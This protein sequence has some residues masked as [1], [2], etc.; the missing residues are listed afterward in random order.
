MARKE[1]FALDMGDGR[2]VRSLE[3]L[4]E[5]F[6]IDRVIGYFQD[7]S[8]LTWLDD[9]YYEEEA[10]AIDGLGMTDPQF[11]EKLCAALGVEYTGGGLD[12]EDA[13]ILREKQEKLKKYH[14][15]AEVLANACRTAF[16]QEDLAD[17][18]DRGED[19]IYLC[20]P[21]FKIPARVK[22]KKYIGIFEKPTIK[23]SV[24]D[25]DE[26]EKRGIQFSNVTVEESLMKAVTTGNAEAS[27]GK[28][29]GVSEED[30]LALYRA[31]IHPKSTWVRVEV[32]TFGIPTYSFKFPP[33]DTKAMV[34]RLVGAKNVEENDVLLAVFLKEVTRAWVLTNDCFYYFIDGKR[35]KVPY[36][37]LIQAQIPASGAPRGRKAG[38][39]LGSVLA[40][41][42]QAQAT[43]HVRGIEIQSNMDEQG[44]FM[45]TTRQIPYVCED[46]DGRVEKIVNFLNGVAGLLQE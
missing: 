8:L 42:V 37:T 16:T 3:E 39:D 9:R 21:T 31:T 35:G 45:V 11:N 22:N 5:A 26:L 12:P 32:D 29:K 2:E 41:L 40:G 46:N 20:G 30:L 25:P 17:L 24:K 4:Q 36:D 6:D 38:S 10:E 15:S 7:G 23:I 28:K 33:E 27:K 43:L 19:T 1:K 44:N 18:L 13:A 34:L 14:A